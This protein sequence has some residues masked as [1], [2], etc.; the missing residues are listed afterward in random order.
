MVLA[1]LAPARRR[2]VLGLIALFAGAIITVVVVVVAMPHGHRSVGPPLADRP[3]PV[4]LVP[5]YGGSVGGLN[6]LAARLRAEGRQVQVVRMPD[7]AVGDLR[8]QARALAGAATSALAAS[9]AR[10]VD[11]VGYSAGGVVARIWAREDG[12]A[13][14]ARRIVTLGAPHHGTQLAGLGAFV[15]GACPTAC[16][17]LAPGSDLLD[18]LNSGDETPS[19]PSYVSIWTTDDR[20]VLPPDSARLDGAL[21]M[22]VQSVCSS[23]TVSHEHLPTDPLVENMV[24]AEL[25]A[26]APVTL[27]ARDCARL[28]S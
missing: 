19:G 23:A 28:S 13:A 27:T 1:A 3:G 9:Q 14:I 18:E 22:T 20:I 15:P 10:S 6:V 25:G 17:Q 2:L 24:I 8:R 11:V 21:N 16:E 4:L 5:G 12:G 26:G 7:N